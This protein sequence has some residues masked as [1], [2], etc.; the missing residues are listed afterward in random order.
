MNS[1]SKDEARGGITRGY[2]LGSGRS[3]SN[4]RVRHSAEILVTTS[5]AGL[6]E[7]I[8]DHGLQDR[9]THYKAVDR[10]QADSLEDWL[11][12]RA[13]LGEH[14]KHWIAKTDAQRRA[15]MRAS[16]DDP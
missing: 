7:G 10:A 11:E 6:L 13:K 5:K 14:D 1:Q 4:L 8:N 16:K 12:K 15:A 3:A 2:G 9:M